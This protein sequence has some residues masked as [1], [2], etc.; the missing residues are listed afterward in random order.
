M[1]SH[2]VLASDCNNKA[3]TAETTGDVGVDQRDDYA[4]GQ[5]SIEMEVVVGPNGNTVVG[6]VTPGVGNKQATAVVGCNNV[7]RKAPANEEVGVVEQDDYAFGITCTEM[8]VVGGPGGST[9]V[10]LVSPGV[11]SEQAAAIIIRGNVARAEPTTEDMGVIEQNNFAFGRTSNETEVVGGPNGDTGVG[12]VSPGVDSNEQAAAIIVR[13][14]VAQEEPTTEDTGV[15]EQKNSAFGR[16]SN[17]TEVVGGPNGDAGVGLVSPGMDNKQATAVVGGRSD[18]NDTV[19]TGSSDNNSN[20]AVAVG[21]GD[22]NETITSIGE[23]KSEARIV[24]GSVSVGA[25]ASELTESV[26]SKDNK[27]SPGG[28][29]GVVEQRDN[30]V[31]DNSNANNLI[32]MSDIDDREQARRIFQHVLNQANN[33]EPARCSNRNGTEEGVAASNTAS[34]E[35]AVGEMYGLFDLDKTEDDVAFNNHNSTGTAG[36]DGGVAN[37]SNEISATLGGAREG[38]DNTKDGEI[39]NDSNN[40]RKR[41]EDNGSNKKRIS[42][43]DSKKNPFHCRPWRDGDPDIGYVLYRVKNDDGTETVQ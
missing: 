5:T 26:S 10:G 18:D 16:T 24:E 3:R 34:N 39:D 41:S 30:E 35:A 22:N 9:G 32:R 29:D 13:G 1:F 4:F 7:V 6:L 21:G 37:S 15:V 40:K 14:N 25:N 42:S 17:E 31:L 36:S 38:E 19:I 20:A 12:L 23:R 43:I 28:V 33:H 8:E 11:D 27:T 2:H